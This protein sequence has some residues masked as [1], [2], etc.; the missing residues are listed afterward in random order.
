MLLREKTKQNLKGLQAHSATKL[1]FEFG[2]GSEVKRK[3]PRWLHL[4]FIL[5][6]GR[7]RKLIHTHLSHLWKRKVIGLQSCW[8]YLLQHFCNTKVHVFIRLIIITEAASNA[9]PLNLHPVGKHQTSTT[10]S[11]LSFSPSTSIPS[12]VSKH[13]YSYFI[14]VIHLKGDKK[15]KQ[16]P[17]TIHYKNNKWRNRKTVQLLVI[18]S[19]ALYSPLQN[20]L[21]LPITNCLWALGEAAY[22]HSSQHELKKLLPG[23]LNS[24]PFHNSFISPSVHHPVHALFA[25]PAERLL[26]AL[27]S[28]DRAQPNYKQATHRLSSIATLPLKC[29]SHFLS[30]FVMATAVEAFLSWPSH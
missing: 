2:Y 24:A 11:L 29:F 21:G 17:R 19:A 30:L 7:K 6:N 10:I 16:L 9:S 23:E 12:H 15:A 8:L 3:A 20:S 13:H 22:L 28:A 18:W 26:S 5:M 27:T 4:K 1:K 14:D 25:H